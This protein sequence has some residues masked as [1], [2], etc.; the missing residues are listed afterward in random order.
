[1]AYSYDWW[2]YLKPFKTEED[3]SFLVFNNYS[4][5]PTTS[6]HQSN[7][8]SLLDELNIK[9]DLFLTYTNLSLTEPDCLEDEIKEA[10][11]KIEKL[12]EKIN[13]RGSWKSTNAKRE[14][15]ITLI[16]EHIAKVKN[17]KKAML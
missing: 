7:T 2:A 14:A 12:K 8:Q 11:L 6:Q 1:M 13:S 10:T 4:Y 15:S 16:R 9:I 5:S 17:L 3:E